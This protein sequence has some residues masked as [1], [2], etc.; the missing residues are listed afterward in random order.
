MNIKRI[1]TG[2]MVKIISGDNKGVSGKVVR[3]LP[4]QHAALVEGVGVKTRH[5]KPSRLQP[6]GGKKDIH[7]PIN[8]SKLALVVDSKS[9][10]TSRVG[11]VKAEGKAT[12]RVARQMNNKEIKHD[13]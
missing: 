3:V 12:V 7:M 6:R 10:K 9:G 5:I 11:Y 13:K 4:S 1:K 2:D 8:L